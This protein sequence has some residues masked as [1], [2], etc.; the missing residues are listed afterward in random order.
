MQQIFYKGFFKYMLRDDIQLW[1][2]THKQQLI[3]SAIFTKSNNFTANIVTWAEKLRCKQ[4]HGF[5]PSHTGSIV[6]RNGKLLIFDM[7][8]PRATTQSLEK[9]LWTS[10]EDFIIVLRNFGLNT[11]T[12]S[13]T[14]LE[15]EGQG[16]PYMSAFRSVLTKQQ[17]KWNCHCSELHL[18]CLQLQGIMT[19]LNA[20]ITPDEL[21]HAILRDDK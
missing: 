13:T 11:D 14:I 6:E 2:D 18:R 19:Y 17:T 7:K 15:H 1:I 9:Y 21:M 8:P 20:E 10:E 4:K 16:Y 5:C 12:F 3:G